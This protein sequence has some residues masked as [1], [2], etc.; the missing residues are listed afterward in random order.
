MNLLL[1]VLLFGSNIETLHVS[2]PIVQDSCPCA[3]PIKN[4]INWCKGTRGG[5]YC[6]TA[7]GEKRY[8][9]KPKI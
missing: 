7:K 6:T 4:T 2:T 1:F 8:K 3:K 9:P 5:Q